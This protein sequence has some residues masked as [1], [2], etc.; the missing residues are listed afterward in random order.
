M[1]FS[2]TSGT[3]EE[4]AAAGERKATAD[5]NASAVAHRDIYDWNAPRRRGEG[6]PAHLLVWRKE[7]FDGG[8]KRHAPPKRRVDEVRCWRVRTTRQQLKRKNNKI[9][10]NDWLAPGPTDNYE[11]TGME[12]T[13][14]TLVTV[15]YF[16]FTGGYFRL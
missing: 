10:G 16:V 2:P 9:I 4:F 13:A 7:I 12:K 6:I 14:V 3:R 1:N 5:Q 8:N 11:K 15:R